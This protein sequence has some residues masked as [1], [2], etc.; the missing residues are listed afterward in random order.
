MERNGKSGATGRV[1][2]VLRGRCARASTPRPK[3][4]SISNGQALNEEIFLEVQAQLGEVAAFN[5]T[6]VFGIETIPCDYVILTYLMLRIESLLSIVSF[7]ITISPSDRVPSL[8]QRRLSPK[9]PR[10]LKSG[11]GR[12][13][14]PIRGERCQPR[15]QRSPPTITN[16][17]TTVRPSPAYLTPLGRVICKKG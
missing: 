4:P 8:H 2:G 11:D 15:G 9:L 5:L 13:T 12:E 3:R 16:C 1:R 7:R 17:K 6:N 10:Y 14:R